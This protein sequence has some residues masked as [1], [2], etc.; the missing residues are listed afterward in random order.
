MSDRKVYSKPTLE[1]LSL[2][3]TQDIGVDIEISLGLGS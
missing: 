2:S 3:D 1:S